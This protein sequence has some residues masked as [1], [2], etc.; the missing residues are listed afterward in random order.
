MSNPRLSAELRTLLACIEAAYP[1][2]WFMAKA[3]KSRVSVLQKLVA[4][5]YLDVSLGP[6][7]SGTNYKLKPRHLW[8][9]AE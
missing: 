7:G 9:N 3:V 4:L 8:P 2:G 6:R 5:G 1:T